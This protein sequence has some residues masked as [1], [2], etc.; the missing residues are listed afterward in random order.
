MDMP[1]QRNTGHAKACPRPLRG[2]TLVE[3][4]IVIA[5][6]AT[7]L[8]LLLPAV[9]SARE[10]ARNVQCKNNLKNLGLAVQS[11]IASQEHYPTAGWGWKNA[12]DPDGGY[13]L[14]QPGGWLY[15]IL[16][17]AEQTQLREIGVGVTKTPPS[18]GN[19]VR[20]I[21]DPVV[22]L[23]YCPSRASPEQLKLRYLQSNC[24]QFPRTSNNQWTTANLGGVIAGNAFFRP[25]HYAGCTG[26]GPMW[27]TN[28]DRV[29][30]T[31]ASPW[32]AAQWANWGWGSPH[33]STDGRRVNGVLG[34]GGLVLPAHITDGQSQTFLAG[35]SF[36]ETKNYARSGNAA[37]SFCSQDQ[38]WTL[39]WDHDTIRHTGH[40]NG[41]QPVPPKRD[42]EVG[43]SN[44]ADY[45]F[46]GPHPGGVNM[47]YCDGSV[48]SIDFEI[49]PGVFQSLGSRNGQELIPQ[50]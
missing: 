28:N 1:R 27:H 14:T 25:T 36:I 19:Y 5:I 50:Y 18:V 48:R 37:G 17:F 11:H 41:T 24:F 44:G 23:F 49:D 34:V 3:L 6:I 43:S 20:A 4:L 2:L 32:T 47:V 8:A 13:G 30:S 33:G 45:G 16:A 38:G 29:D 42:S 9:Q 12:F 39:G 35:E 26:M 40:I 10:S 22:P 31:P 15:Q 21:Y 7:L 46:G